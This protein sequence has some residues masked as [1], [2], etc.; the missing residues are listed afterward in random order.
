[1]AGI[2][3]CVGK[4]IK[5]SKSSI[6]IKSE[7]GKTCGVVR[8]IKKFKDIQPNKEFRYFHIL[9]ECGAWGNRILI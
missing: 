4:K 1:M 6:T 5:I 2:K 9:K 3:D 8:D 7:E